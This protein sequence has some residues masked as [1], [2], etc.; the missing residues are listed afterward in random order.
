MLKRITINNYK[1]FT[2]PTIID[3]S[4]TNYKFLEE[5]NLV[6]INGDKILK[7]VVFVGDNATGKTSI[8]D[9]VCILMRL[10]FSESFPDCSQLKSF[11]SNKKT[12]SI[13][14]EF[15]FNYDD[16][17]Y[18]LEFDD[19]GICIEKLDLNGVEKITRKTKEHIFI[20][21]KKP[22]VGLSISPRT[23][24]LKW[25]LNHNQIGK[26]NSVYDMLS[27]VGKSIFVSCMAFDSKICADAD[28][29]SIPNS[30]KDFI[31]RN[32]EA[33]NT[34]LE[35]LSHHFTVKTMKRTGIDNITN[36]DSLDNK[37]VVMKRVG[38]NINIPLEQESSGNKVLIKLL[39]YFI[40]ATENDCMLLIDEFSSGLQNSIEEYLVRHFFLDTTEKAV[41]SQLILATHSTNL[42]DNAILRPDQEYNVQFNTEK[43]TYL[44]RFSD[45]N[46]R[47]A[48]NVEKMYLSGVFD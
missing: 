14:Y 46:P 23:A 37:L 25:L 4:A 17:S 15:K 10:L 26:N 24:F 40:T 48:Q 43:G 44:T 19:D 21:A 5:T 3:L 31:D 13:K 12:F 28:N 38:T 2:N 39:P 20:Y 35:S 22:F 47:E 34:F 33:I 8:L 1:T 45:Q 30:Y 16:V 18:E 32:P 7:G 29:A 11:Y 27:F 36:S 41:K 9:A 6:K 42:L